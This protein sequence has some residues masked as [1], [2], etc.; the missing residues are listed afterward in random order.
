LGHEVAMVTDLRVFPDPETLSVA[1]AGLVSQTAKECAAEKG[2]FAMALSGGITPQRLYELLATRFAAL[3]PWGAVHLFWSDERCVPPDAP[4]SNFRPVR[5]SLLNRVALPP[6]NIHRVRGEWPPAK[7]AAEYEAKIA[8]LFGRES[9]FP[10]FD[11]VLLGIGADG[12]TASLF[13]GSPALSETLRWAVAAQAPEGSPARHRVTLTLPV[14]NAARRVLFLASGSEKAPAVR[15]A[16]AREPEVGP[17]SPA[18]RVRPAGA[19]FWFVD[20]LAAG[21]PIL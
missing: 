21:D 3:I 4:A 14:L 7:A 17:L 12:H 18:A 16:M 13:P 6:Q 11:L 2:R 15:M 10:E 20:R 9:S 8:N 1:A 5:E 19:L